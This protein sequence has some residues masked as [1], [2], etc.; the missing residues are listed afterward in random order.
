M[1]DLAPA[2]VAFHV[3]SEEPSPRF[4]GLNAA[5]RNARVVRRAGKLAAAEATSNSAV[6]D[7][8]PTLTIPAGVAITPALIRA[9][10]PPNGVCHLAWDTGRPPLVWQGAGA[11]ATSAPVTMQLPDGA[12]LDVSNTAVRRRSAWRLL[13]ASGKPTDGWLSRHVH[14]RISRVCSYVLLHLG[15]TANQAT[16]LVFFVGAAAA[17]FLSQTTHATLIAGMA[18]FWF[19]S[20]ADGIDGEMARLTLS[21][22]AYGEQLDTAVDHATHLSALAG[23]MVGWWRQGI[24]PA[25]WVLATAVG[26]GVPATLLWGMH[27]VRRAHGI[28]DRFF[29]DTKPIEIGVTAAARATGAPMLRLASGVFVLLRR[30]VFS[31]TF[32]LVAF[33]TAQRIVY[34]ALLAGGLAVV[35]ATLVSYRAEI[36]DSRAYSSSKF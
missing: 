26:V 34:P 22:S 6:V 35:A 11:R 28:H 33:V 20:V 30:E 8:A 3:V 19:A 23:V 13:R 15:L 27:V 21:E 7:G 14:R 9:L 2:T 31:L 4:L 25:G 12:A 10:P 17:W 16:I 29:V 1:T 24:G 18:L 5:E 32:L 36:E